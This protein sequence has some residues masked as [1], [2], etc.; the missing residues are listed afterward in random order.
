VA[1]PVIVIQPS[2]VAASQRHPVPVVTLNDPLPPSTG[3][4]Q[5]LGLRANVQLA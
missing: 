5:L 2:L 1:P 3:Y 4:N